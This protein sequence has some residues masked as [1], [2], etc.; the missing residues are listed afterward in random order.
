M[1]QKF[2]L[3]TKILFWAVDYVDKV[4]KS[5]YFKAISDRDSVNFMYGDEFMAKKILVAGGAGYI[6]SHVQKQL[7]EEGFDVVIYDDLSSG[8]K[9]NVLKGSEFVLGNILDREKLNN[10]MGQGIDGVVHLAAKKAVGES[11]IN[12]EIYAENNITGALNILNAMS[13]NGVKH[14][15]FSSSAAVYGMPLYTPID[16]NHPINPINYYGYTKVA[17]EQNMEWYAKL[18]KLNYAALRYFNAVG[19]AKDKSIKGKERNPQNLMPIIMEVATGKRDKLTIYG[20]DYDT[21]DGTCVRDYVHVSDLAKA[22]TTALR[23]LIEGHPSFAVNLGTG[24]GTSVKEIVEATERVIGKKLNHDYGKRR[25][26]DPAILTAKADKAY[27]ILNWKPDYTNIEDI[28]RT[29]W[30]LEI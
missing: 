29:V 5:F 6:G 1:E 30:N 23:L 11:M 20:Q 9:V 18:N 8:D 3:C 4:S 15:V 14:I 26:G 19:Y 7:L 24:K 2:C 28:I 21:P 25:A 22:H 10:V 27:E 13:Y 17:I 16:E 12:P